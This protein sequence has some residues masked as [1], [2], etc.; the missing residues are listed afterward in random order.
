MEAPFTLFFKTTVY[1]GKGKLS[2]LGDIL[3]TLNASKVLVVTDQGIIQSGVIKKCLD[4][5][6]QDPMSFVVFDE[7]E[8]NPTTEAVYQGL[9]LAKRE[10]IDLIMAVGGGS[11]ID[12]AKA[13]NVLLANGGKIEDY[14]GFNRVGKQ[15]PPLVAVPTTA[16]TGS[17]MTSFML[18]S[19]SNTHQKIVCSDS[20]IIPGVA[21][22]DPALTLSMPVAVTAATGLDALSHGIESYLSKAANPYSGTLALRATE[23]IFRHITRVCDEPSDIEARGQ[24]LMAANMAGLAVHLSY[25]GAAHSMANPLTGHCKVNHGFAVGMVLPYVMLFNAHAS[26]D[27]D[28]YTKIALALGVNQKEGEDRFTF[29]WKGAKKLRDLLDQ[30]SLP[31]SL[32]EMG[33]GEDLIPV[34]AKEALTQLSLDYNPVKPNLEQMETLFLAAIRGDLSLVTRA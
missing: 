16:G 23:M 33:V 7:V 32:A 10:R 18:I 25:L 13:I 19:D 31:A 9:S 12:A 20:K 1:Y 29:A 30:L 22:L 2:E 27:V 14:R 17:E 4:G 5:M 26:S 11:C 24:M 21:V 8:P 3:R 6:A 34:M 28:K 15:G